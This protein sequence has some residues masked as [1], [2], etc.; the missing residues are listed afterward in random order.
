MIIAFK[1]PHNNKTVKI[2]EFAF[3]DLRRFILYKGSYEEELQFLNNLLVTEDLNN[4]EKVA[5]FLILRK[6]CV[7]E[8]ISLNTSSKHINV[9]VD[10]LLNNITDVPDITET[11]YIDN[12][13]LELDYPQIFVNNTKDVLFSVIKSIE[14]EGVKI[15]L[16]TQ[17]SDDYNSIVER[18]PAGALTACT[19]F[20]KKN[21]H[22]FNIQLLGERKHLGTKEIAINLLDQSAGRFC[23]YIFNTMSESSFRDIVFIL[24]KRINDVQF[25]MNSTPLEVD[26]YIKLY[27]EEVAR[28]N[29]ALKKETIS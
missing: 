8:E 28:E 20:I 16:H 14:I 22:N 9:H 2:K 5:A 19:K 21:I 24:S 15:I 23:T 18:L 11:V 3:K 13:I 4:L 12:F 25:L 27:K 10:V 29:E 17:E 26:D 7:G 6:M 1:L